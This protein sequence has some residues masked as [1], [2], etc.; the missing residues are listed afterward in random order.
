[1]RLRHRGE[2]HSSAVPDATRAKR[3]T[4]GASRT[5]A[6]V[7]SSPTQP[8]R[9]HL[10]CDG[11]D[12]FIDDASFEPPATTRADGGAGELRAPF[13]GK[14]LAVKAAAGDAVEA[15]ATL[16]VIESMKLEH[17][18]SLPRSGRIAQVRVSAGQQVA[19]GQVLATL[20]DA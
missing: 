10:Q 18:L 6:V 2:L 1:M 19:P 15:G 11:M 12:A 16:V 8:L 17:A 14:V 13:N 9:L 20:E 4:E 5:V 3:Q 7:I